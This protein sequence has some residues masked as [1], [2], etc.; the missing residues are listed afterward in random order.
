MAVGGASGR[1]I[2]VRRIYR[3]IRLRCIET[4]IGWWGIWVLAASNLT[5]AFAAGLP[6]QPEAE[7]R[8]ARAILEEL[9]EV[10]ST[11]A[12]GTTR[13]AQAVAA[14]FLSAGFA[15]SDVTLLEPEPGKGNVVVRYRGKGS[16]KPVLFTVH[17]DV[18]DAD[19]ADWTVPPFELTEKDGTFFGR[20]V[21]D[22]KGEAANLIANLIRLRQE[23]F[24]PARDVVV[25]F[26]S[27]EEGGGTLNG[28]K[29]LLEHR[30]ELIEAEFVINHDSG[31]GDL[32]G[33]E[34]TALRLQTAEKGYTTY[35]LEVTNPG[36]H[37]SMPPR[38]NALYRLSAGLVKLA[39]FEF[40]ARLGATTR[41]YF[42]RL[43][44]R[45]SGQRAHDLKLLGRGS[46]DAA[47]L[48]RVS[49]S[50]AV[51]NATL[52]TTCV[53][54]MLQ[55]GHAE[56]AL[57][58]RALATIQCRLLPGDSAK[59]VQATLASVL[60]DPEI[61]IRVRTDNPP[62][63]ASPLRAELLEHVQRIAGTLWPGV[64]VIPVMDPWTSD[65]SLMRAAGM[66]VYGISGIFTDLENN[67]AHGRDERMGVRE[68]YEG[69]EFSYRLLKAVASE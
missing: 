29:W 60:A 69:V 18:V 68:F 38:E 3:E 47:V 23:R 5:S 13:A 58:L 27:D 59:A 17:L 43:A 22:I 33:G 2:T 52:R 40:P 48:E 11:H 39:E 41:T 30:R 12:K 57:P 44:A 64:P 49:A 37:S 16:A 63:P 32:V 25:A 8:R 14:R 20:G 56:N 6:A 9:I 65:G 54:T 61:A 28:V 34:R 19:P 21:I 15:P 7:R 31:G 55:A 51:Y 24:V 42:A 26:T 53:A 45:E 62:A 67:G 66:P 35:E 36:G 10:D 4:R 50:S 1:S 46:A